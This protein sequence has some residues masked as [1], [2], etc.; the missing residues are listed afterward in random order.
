MNKDQLNILLGAADKWF[1]MALTREAAGNPSAAD[2]CL[3]RACDY[4]LMGL[5][6]S[7]RFRPGAAETSAKE[8]LQKA[9][10]EKNKTLHL[11]KPKKTE[12][13]EVHV[14]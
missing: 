11:P 10:V 7:P 8:L 14:G 6:F 12:I 4:E 2:A 9:E 13:H 5:G 1:K 3:E